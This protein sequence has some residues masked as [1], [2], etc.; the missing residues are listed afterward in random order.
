M[1]GAFA[2]LPHIKGGLLSG[3]GGGAFVCSPV[4][5]GAQKKSLV[6]KMTVERKTGG[7]KARWKES[8]VCFEKHG[9]KLGVSFF[10]EHIKINDK[11]EL[12]H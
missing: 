5:Q 3:G 1:R 7:R 2:L 9:K 10:S 11:V 4:Y 12:K 8:L 6:E